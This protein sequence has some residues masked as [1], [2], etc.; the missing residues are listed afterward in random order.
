MTSLLAPLPL[1]YARLQLL[2]LARIESVSG[3]LIL[4]AFQ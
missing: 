2:D 3:Q 4:E 1:D